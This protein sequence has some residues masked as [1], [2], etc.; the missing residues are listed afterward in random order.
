M[1]VAVVAKYAAELFTLG[2]A[3]E[4][5]ELR[6][7]KFA[8]GA[9]RAAGFLEAFNSGADNTVDRM[10]AMGSASRL[11]Q[12]G[13]VG[14]TDEMETMASIAVKLG[15]QTKG[16]GDRIADFSLLLSN[17]ATLRLDN[18]GISSGKV[19]DRINEL[20]ASGEALNR[21]E[22]FKMAVMEEG[23]RAL[24]ILGDDLVRGGQ[25]NRQQGHQD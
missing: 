9:D 2:V 1:A 6:F 25:E 3:A 8:G 17:Q 23:S 13:L 19:R 22:A 21:E 4:A 12:M 7:T 10:T 5:A 24:A 20:I 16:A 11:L 15:D 18:F 14:N